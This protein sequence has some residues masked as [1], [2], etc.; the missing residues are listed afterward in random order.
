MSDATQSKCLNII[1]GGHFRSICDLRDLARV[2]FRSDIE[3]RYAD[4][5]IYKLRNLTPIG[6]WGDIYRG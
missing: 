5:R 1:N 2:E 6:F 4:R 3:Q